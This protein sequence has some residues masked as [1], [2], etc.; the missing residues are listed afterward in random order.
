MRSQC[1]ETDDEA[2]DWRTLNRRQRNRLV[3]DAHFARYRALPRPRIVYARSTDDTRIYAQVH[4][5]EDGTTIVL[6]H[7]ICCDTRFWAH[8]IAALSATFRVVAYDHRG[9]GRSDSP[10]TR[11][12]SIA[13]LAD[14]LE[15]VLDQTLPPGRRAV[16]VGHSMGG[17]AIWNWANR[18]P[19]SVA[20]FAQSVALVNTAPGDIVREL[21]LF[22]VPKA[23]APARHAVGQVAAR[24]VGG[25]PLPA[26]LQ[27]RSAAIWYLAGR[28]M[29]LA[30]RA[31]LQ[32]MLLGTK[33]TTRGQF[34]RSL[35]AMNS[36]HF[37]GSHLT[38]PTLVIGGLSDRLLPPVH[39]Q[40]IAANL[41][42]SAGLVEVPGGHCSPLEQPEAINAELRR[43]AVM[44]AEANTA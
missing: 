23:L 11:D 32:E 19:E 10:P 4:G 16:I 44:G 6:S 28:E 3:Q 33:S 21:G 13:R 37:D 14:D 41:P 34:I 20:R 5:P 30:D 15:A 8:Q 35:A 18:Y 27:M 26:K 38:V 42:N 39:A 7:G 36:N 24:L 43:L 17:I 22:T 31:L 29:R 25:I 9:H 12:Y 1:G 40:R 2:S